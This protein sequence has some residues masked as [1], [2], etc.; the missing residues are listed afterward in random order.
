MHSIRDIS[1]MKCSICSVDPKLYIEDLL[2]KEP[3]IV[4]NSVHQKDVPKV[5]SDAKWPH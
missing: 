5:E 2:Q 1:I 3:E 4:L